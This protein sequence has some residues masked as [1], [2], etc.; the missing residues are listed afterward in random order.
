MVL[1]HQTIATVTNA[2]TSGAGNP[3][4][5][6]WEFPSHG[7]NCPFSRFWGR[8][9]PTCQ[10]GPIGLMK[11][12]RMRMS[13]HVTPSG[14]IKSNSS[15]L[16]ITRLSA[17]APSISLKNHFPLPQICQSQCPNLWRISGGGLLV[18]IC[19]SRLFLHVGSRT[20]CSFVPNFT[21]NSEAAPRYTTYNRNY[22]TYGESGKPRAYEPIPLS[23]QRF[24]D[25]I[26]RDQYHRTTGQT[27]KVWE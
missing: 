12:W 2:S 24:C 6:R 11:L 7:Q 22:G 20:A 26:E 23:V 5:L 27:R 4:W 21:K 1:P 16:L 17:V 3:H 25:G 14:S 10:F 18:M 13:A 9:F 8:E 19:D 15:V